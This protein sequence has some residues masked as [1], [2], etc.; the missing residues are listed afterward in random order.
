MPSPR[1][2]NNPNARGG[3]TYL[4][5]KAPN[6]RLDPVSIVENDIRNLKR[7]SLFDIMV[8][9]GFINPPKLAEGKPRMPK[10]VTKWMMVYSL[11][12]IFKV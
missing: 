2:K 11:H 4:M 6:A 9:M 7:L 3:A 10:R 1:S 8:N 5:P 12:G